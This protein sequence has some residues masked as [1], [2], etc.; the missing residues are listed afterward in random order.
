MDDERTEP[1]LAADFTFVARDPK[2]NAAWPVNP[3]ICETRKHKER[4]QEIQASIYEA[5]SEEE[6]AVLNDELIKHRSD[7]VRKTR[8]RACLNQEM[9]ALTAGYNEV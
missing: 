9:P 3:L 1:A 2:T 8:E 6:D 4:F 7:W 5:S